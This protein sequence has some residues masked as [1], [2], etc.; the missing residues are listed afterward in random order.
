MKV[1]PKWRI[2]FIFVAMKKTVNSIWV[3]VLIITVTITS[4]CLNGDDDDMESRNLDMEMEE[5][6]SYLSGLVA[7]GQ[8]IDTSDL[9]IYYILKTEGEGP[10]AQIGDTLSLEY[11]GYLLD[12]QIFDASAY[13]HTDST[14]E[15]VF[16]E[17]QLIQGFSDG[18]SLM[19]KGAEIDM[20]IPSAFAYGPFGYGPIEPYTTLV[21]ETKMHDITPGV[22]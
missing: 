3:F 8:D 15:F 19:N 21:F 13:H 1:F 7:E 12:G 17:N 16:K 18:I 6:D 22:N 11:T 10:L 5:L 4:S 20:I 2:F 9:G 14:W